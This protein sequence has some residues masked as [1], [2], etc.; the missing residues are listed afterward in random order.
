LMNRKHAVLAQSL[1]SFYRQHRTALEQVQKQAD[2]GIDQTV[3]NFILNQRQEPM[4][5]LPRAYNH[6]GCFQIPF[7]LQVDIR[8]KGKTIDFGALKQAQSFDFI[9]Y[10][11]VW[12][13]TNG[14]SDVM[15]RRVAMGETWRLIQQHYPDARLPA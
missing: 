9:D 6:V 5:F 7:D 4:T 15:S 8:L 12:H 10:S 1:L 3:L 2:V 13:F 11:Y 14:F